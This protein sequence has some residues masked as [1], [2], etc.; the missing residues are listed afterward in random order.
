MVWGFGLMAEGRTPSELNP[1]TAP[2]SIHRHDR[3]E[4]QPKAGH[5]EILRDGL[6]QSVWYLLLEFRI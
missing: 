3:M 4:S 2:K 5:A 6:C 1:Q